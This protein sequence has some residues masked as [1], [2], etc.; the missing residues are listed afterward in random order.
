VTDSSTLH[1]EALVFDL[2]Q[3]TLSQLVDRFT[4]VDVITGNGAEGKDLHVTIPR[5]QN[6][7]VDA[8]CWAIF[9]H[10]A[11]KTPDFLERAVTMIGKAHRIVKNGGVTIARTTREIREAKEV[12]KTA[13]VLT[14]ENAVVLRGKLEMLYS[15]YEMGIRIIGLVW[16]TRNELCAGFQTAKNGEGLTSFG[17]EV[18]QEMAQ[19]G[20]I[21]DVAHLDEPGVRSVLEATD[22]PVISTHTNSRGACNF[23]RNHEDDTIR[24]ISRRGGV[25]GVNF[26]PKF[27]NNTEHA[28]VDDVVRMIVHLLEVAGPEGVALGSDYDGIRRPPSGIDT[29][30]K[31]PNLTDA[32]VREGLD[33]NTIRGVLGGNALRVFQTVCG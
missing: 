2:H 32:L 11:E 1:R 20:M 17:R 18:V 14:I 7:G 26:C 19:L 16:N 9:T 12:G 10:S 13:V 25:L 24:E 4:D 28:D 31:L 8:V 29:P 33:E 5:L 15:F 27:L 21:V 30:D 22:A 3:D 6:G 23:P